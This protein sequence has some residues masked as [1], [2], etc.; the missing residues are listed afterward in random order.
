MIPQEH[1]DFVEQI[2]ADHGVPELPDEETRPRELLGWTAATAA[3]Q[4]DVRAPAR[5]GAS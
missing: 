3:P 2:L 4:V 5:E 1:R